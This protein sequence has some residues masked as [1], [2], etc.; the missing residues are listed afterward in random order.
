[1]VNV[2]KYY[3][4]DEQGMALSTVIACLL[5]LPLNEV[6]NFHPVGNES[7]TT[8]L[9]DQYWENVDA[10]L[11]KQGY[12]TL[13]YS[14]FDLTLKEFHLHYKG[15]Y[16]VS[17][18]TNDNQYIPLIFKNGEIDHNPTNIDIDSIGYSIV[19]L[20]TINKCM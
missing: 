9:V 10:F 20:M 8:E 11:K 5:D 19:D 3:K 14:K 16:I 2:M 12:F 1:M 17:A 15:R 7:K 13:D 4:N 18:L 6:P